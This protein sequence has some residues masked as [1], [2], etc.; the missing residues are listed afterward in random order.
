MPPPGPVV[1]TGMHRSGT[2]LTARLV[3][4]LGVDLGGRLLPA[5]ATNPFG[6]FEDLDFL[7]LQRRLLRQCCAG[8]EGG[9]PDWGWTPAGR[10]RPE[11]L[12][13]A[14]AEAAALVAGRGAAGAL[15]GWKDPRTSLLLPFWDPLLP[16]ARYLFVYRPPWEVAA[17]IERTGHPA[18]AA[19]PEFGV[20]AWLA[21]NRAILAFLREHP[22][23]CALV[24]VG[25]VVAS[26]GV[27]ADLLSSRLGIPLPEPATDLAPLVD[28]SIIGRPPAPSPAEGTPSL[29]REA[30]EVLE[31]LDR[32]AGIGPPGR[33][34][35]PAAAPPPPRP[36]GAHRSGA[37]LSVVIPC[38]NHGEFLMEAV[39]SVEA[40]DD[41]RHE[42]V[43]VDDGSD[44]A[45]SPLVF[46]RLEER[47]HR[48]LRLPRQ[49]LAR[50]R[51]AGIAEAHGEFI[52]PLDAD[53]CLQPG[54]V[55][56]GIRILEREPRVG[57]VYGDAERFGEA[58]GRWVLGPFDLDRLVARNFV[59]ACAVL[60]R[61]LWE[62]CGG[63]DAGMP[64][65]GWE[66]WDLWLGGA[67]RGWEFAYVPEVL[68]RYRVRA[69][70]MH[71]VAAR[72]ENL[73]R[74]YSY[75]FVKH[76]PL[77]E[78]RLPAVL[79]DAMAALLA[80]RQARWA[81]EGRVGAE[82]AAAEERVRVLEEALGEERRLAAR[83]AEAIAALEGRR[84]RLEDELERAKEAEGSRLGR[85]EA[86]REELDRMQGTRTWRLRSRVLDTLRR[87]LARLRSATP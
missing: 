39:A 3:R 42:I 76:R 44:D 10:L 79:G 85:I 64:V 23:R 61:R 51:N 65:Q 30:G 60:R 66:D 87:G 4:A 77:F 38:Y 21:Y 62:E 69:D 56:E 14:G 2:S 83:Q 32:V 37:R 7:E 74:L 9:W 59:D 20:R 70:A 57:V 50:A 72:P 6:Y 19:D 8:L 33:R 47:G 48:V 49:G 17:S 53:N 18:Q 25:G 26:P 46:D 80:E 84:D 82:H 31:E 27:V 75:L 41:E 35:R 40:I 5:D 54:Y 29:V 36:R 63:Y 67:A 12:A 73:R 13:S 78:P 58:E 81:A 55:T 24:P 68:F 11:P 86:L 43:V 16:R 1:V 71:V 22:G 45:V 34:I 15:W 28:A 52:L